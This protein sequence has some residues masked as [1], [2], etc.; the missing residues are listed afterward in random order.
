MCIDRNTGKTLW[1]KTAREEVPHEGTQP[2]NTFASAS[3]ITDGKVLIA[4]FGS[5]GLYCYDM[6]GNLKWTKQLGQMR[7]RN[8]FGEGASPTLHGDMV[9]VPWDDEGDTDFIAA[10]NKNDGKEI[11]R[12]PRNEPT[13]WSTPLVVEHGNKPQVVVNATKKSRSYDLATGTEIWSCGGQTANAIP[14]PVADANTVYLT[15]GF[16]GSAVYAVKLDAKGD[17]SDGDAV[18]WKRN[19]NTPYVP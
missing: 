11:W 9:I 3:P 12:T 8:G 2:N 19:Q 13:G 5:R 10:F 16:M 4:F 18:L 15:S 6:D 17:V 7:T 14:S 1:Q